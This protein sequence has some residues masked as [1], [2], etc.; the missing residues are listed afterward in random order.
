MRQPLVLGGDAGGALVGVALLGLDAADRQHRLAGDVDHVDAEREGGDGAAGQAEFARPDERHP[1]GEV[2]QG[3]DAVDPGEPDVERKGHTVGEDQGSGAGAAL[4]TVDGDEVDAALPVGHRVGQLLPERQVSDRR[5]DADRQPGLGGQ[6]LDPVEQRVDVVEGRVPRR[7][8]AVLAL[9]DA[10]DLGDLGGDLRTRQNTAEPGLGALG[11]LDL[12]RPHR[13]ARDGV[14][15]PAEVERA[16]LVAAAEIAGADLPD[17]FAALPVVGRQPA[18]TGVVHR[19]GEL[20]PFVERDD[21]PRRQRPEAHRRHVHHRVGPECLGPTARSAEDLRARQPHVIAVVRV[22]RRRHDAER[23][24]LDDRVALLLLDVVVGAEA[25]VVVLAL[26]GRVDPGPLRAA[27]RALLVVGG[28]DVLPHLRADGFDRVPRVPDH[29]VVA[30][31]RVLLLQQ[32]VRCDTGRSHGRH[33]G[34]P[35]DGLHARQSAPVRDRVGAN[36]RTTGSRKVGVPTARTP[37]GT[38]QARRA[39][40]IGQFPPDLRS[41]A[42]T[43]D[44]MTTMKVNPAWHPRTT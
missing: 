25:D 20:D 3:E 26:G 39:G 33:G 24:L 12:Q 9:G 18:L 23:A 27:E 30:Q 7:A 19:P 44:L 13:R 14:L 16:V 37:D 22:G 28:H 41:A 4:T 43:P 36:T 42:G 35:G 40:T 2:A 6:Q 29:R 5:L 10:T 34:Q 8:D 11:D 17:E 15:Q 32:V 31:Q 38:G 1:L 21:R